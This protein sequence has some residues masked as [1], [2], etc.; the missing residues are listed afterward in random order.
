MP[1]GIPLTQGDLNQ[2]RHDVFDASVTL[3]LRKGFHE[4][5]MQEIANAAGMGKSTLYDYFKTKDDIL[6]SFVEDA[7]F[8]LTERA[9]EI[10]AQ[11]FPAAESLHQVLRAHMEYLMENKE[12]FL[13]LTFEVQRLAL[14]SQQRIQNQRHIYQDLIC[15]LIEDAIREGVF[16]PI[17]P[18]LATRTIL[19]LLTPAVYTSRPTGTPEQM[20]EEALDI[21]YR[22]V[23]QQA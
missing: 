20:M 16:R 23:K 12:F 5:T 22:G 8:D 2:R 9:K 17:N 15:G 7:I 14:D 18:L 4:T 11:T 19:S 6:V 10:S 1:K 13:K 21:F 3:F